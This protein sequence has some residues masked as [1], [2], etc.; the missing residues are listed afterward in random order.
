MGSCLLNLTVCVCVCGIGGGGAQAAQ[1]EAGQ[2]E[3]DQ[4]RAGIRPLYIHALHTYILHVS[5]D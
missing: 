1:G 5:K 4:S 2:E 3:G